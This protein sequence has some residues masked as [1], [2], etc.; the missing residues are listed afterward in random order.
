MGT[1]LNLY[2]FP[3][4]DAPPSA[5]G[6]LVRRLVAE[7]WVELP[8]VAGS[9][10]REE[11]RGDVQSPQL[12]TLPGSRGVRH[13]RNLPALEGQLKH[14]EAEPVLLVFPGLNENHADVRR[15]F[16]HYRGHECSVGFYAFPAGHRVKLVS[17]DPS[18]TVGDRTTFDRTV[19]C[20]CQLNGKAAIWESLFR[21]SALERL[22]QAVWPAHE[23]VENDWL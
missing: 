3:A 23:I 16:D 11:P 12:L 14:G 20:W 15:E 18:G 17:E 4:S 8:A 1:I 21:G 5:L 2:V 13:V 22:F 10:F 19:R 6:P 7:S 9:P